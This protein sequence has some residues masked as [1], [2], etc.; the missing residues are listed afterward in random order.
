MAA[1]VAVIGASRS[2]GTAGREILHNIVSWGFGGDVYAVNP[3]GGSMEGLSFL[4][5]AAELP[6]GVDVA[7]I[8]VP[9]AEV[10][11]AAEQCG[12][13]GKERGRGR[14]DPEEGWS[15]PQS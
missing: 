6:A 14:Q 8:A 12:R 7:V 9:P 10:T 4:T 5:S 11:G 13:R 15:Q 1:S 3:A 2:R